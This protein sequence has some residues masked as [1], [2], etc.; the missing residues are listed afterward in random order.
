MKSAY[1]AYRRAHA[2]QAASQVATHSAAPVLPSIM[3][4][5]RPDQT[6]SP[7]R[8][9]LRRFLEKLSRVASQ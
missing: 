5:Y 2:H 6:E 4:C 8:M 7:F 3:D 9:T 1:Y